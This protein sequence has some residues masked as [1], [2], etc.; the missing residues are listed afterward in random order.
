MNTIYLVY[1]LE[2]FL[3]ISIEKKYDVTAVGITKDNTWYVFNDDID[4][5]KEDFTK[6]NITKIENIIKYLNFTTFL[7]FLNY[8]YNSGN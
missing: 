3:P 4:L 2:P 5:L 1:Q 6:G 7:V 8:I